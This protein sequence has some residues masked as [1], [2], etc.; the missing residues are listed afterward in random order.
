MKVNKRIPLFVVILVVIVVAFCIGKIINANTKYS[1]KLSKIYEKLNNSQTYLFEM[2]KNSGNKIIMAKKGDK[3]VINQYSRDAETNAES[4]TTT[5]VKDNNTYL[6]LHDRQEYYVYEQNNV[7]QTILTDG[8]K[9][10][11]ERNYNVG[12]EKVK[13]KKYSYEEYEDLDIDSITGYEY[14]TDNGTMLYF[15]HQDPTA[16]EV[17]YVFHQ[18]EANALMPVFNLG[19]ALLIL[20]VSIST[21]TTFIPISEKHVPET[22]PT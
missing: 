11:L 16:Q 20:F 22:K 19:I 13:G 18:T 14:Q 12:S 15:D 6:I 7:E 2:E 10:I 9:E 3:T 5:L 17:Q 1:Q 4:H 8:I 21:Q